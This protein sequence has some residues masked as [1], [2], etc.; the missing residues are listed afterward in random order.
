VAVIFVNLQCP[1]EAFNG[2]LV[3]FL[4]E[5][6]EPHV[7]ER[8]TLHASLALALTSEQQA[9]SLGAQLDG[10]FILPEIEVTAERVVIYGRLRSGQVEE[11]IELRSFPEVLYCLRI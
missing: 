6:A 5:V 10:F 8:L 9:E 2:F 1:S 4:L 11:A 3:R 7:D